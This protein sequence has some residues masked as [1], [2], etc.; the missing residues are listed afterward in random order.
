[1]TSDFDTQPSSYQYQALNPTK[2][3]IRLFRRPGHQET[4]CL[5]TYNLDEAPP[6]TAL[7]YMWGPPSPTY[8]VN[9]ED[10]TLEVRENLF[11]FLQER[12]QHFDYDYYWVDQIC[13]DQTNVAE[14]SS[15][16]SMMSEIYTQATSTLIWLGGGTLL[17]EAAR[18]FTR[19]MD[20]DALITILNDQYFTRLWVVQEIMLARDVQ[21]L[22]RG[23]HRFTWR[24][25]DEMFNDAYWGNNRKY[26]LDNAPSS[27]TALLS[28]RIHRGLKPSQSLYDAIKYFSNNGCQD[29]RDRVYG[30]LG[31]VREHERVVVD[32]SES[33]EEVYLSVLRVLS[34]WDRDVYNKPEE[35]HK[36]VLNLGKTMGL[37]HGQL[38]GLDLFL[39]KVLKLKPCILPPPAAA[40]S[41]GIANVDDVG[42]M[43]DTWNMD[44]MGDIGDMGY[45]RAHSREDS[46]FSK[47]DAGTMTDRWWY[48]FRH[49]WHDAEWKRHF[50]DCDDK[51]RIYSEPR[52]PRVSVSAALAWDEEAGSGPAAS[53]TEDEMLASMLKRLEAL[54]FTPPMR[55]DNNAT[56]SYEP[57]GRSPV[58]FTA[59]EELLDLEKRLRDLRR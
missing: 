45:E 16:V 12:E 22:V 2:R 41:D 3:Q 10:G 21:V 14:V 20:C 1:M 19:S 31:I 53:L 36:V 54:R 23:N 42:D 50:H 49:L 57:V 40:I 17:Q 46:K 52:T 58:I 56:L 48:D 33:V 26:I 8:A 38:T 7:S 27:A 6:Y 51:G 4:P 25:L 28:R 55:G 24:Q 15:Q 18:E 59:D 47:Q 30:L 34:A 11:N 5:T 13:I 29:P 44:E 39:Y 37:G 35:V 43:F 9:I 32:Y